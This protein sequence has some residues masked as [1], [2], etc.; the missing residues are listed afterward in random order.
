V[1]VIYVIRSEIKSPGEA[2]WQFN[3]FCAA[4]GGWL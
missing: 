2:G 1:P 3:R 4:F